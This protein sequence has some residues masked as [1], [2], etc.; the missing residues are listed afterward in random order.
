MSKLTKEEQLKLDDLQACGF[1]AFDTQKERKTFVDKLC[2][3]I[4][5]RLEPLNENNCHLWMEL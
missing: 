3:D 4:K 1:V 5:E 2:P